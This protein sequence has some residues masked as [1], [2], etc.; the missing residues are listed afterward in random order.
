MCLKRVLHFLL[1]L[2]VLLFTSGW[3]GVTAMKV[4]TSGRMQAVN[5]TDVRL[6]CTFQSSVPV[7]RSTLTISW[8]FRPLRPGNEESVFYF[9]DKPFPPIEGRFQNKV[10]FVGDVSSS[11]ASIL[12][13]DVT[14]SFNGTFSCQVKNP[15]D[16][17]GNVGEV[18]L[19]VVA[20]APFS[21]IVILAVAIG[22]AVLLVIVI[23]AICVF[24]R[25]CQKMKRKE[26]RQEKLRRVRKDLVVW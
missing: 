5:G 18:Q 22:G 12:L 11:D 3:H 13:R 10:L 26:E 6:K 25:R 24:I 17:H 1:F 16:V 2:P 7:K 21:E 4:Y 9:Q 14:F 20:S 23:L 19:R 15:P 8:S